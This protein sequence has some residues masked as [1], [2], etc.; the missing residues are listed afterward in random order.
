[1]LLDSSDSSDSVK[2]V[3]HNSPEAILLKYANDFI[4]QSNF[5]QA[6]FIHE[7]LLPALIECGLEKPGDYTTGDEYENW[8]ISKVRQMN[9]ILRGHTNLP[10]R[11]MW[12]WLDVLPAPYGPSARKELLAQGSVLDVSIDCSKQSAKRADLAQLFREV[13][14][15][16][17]AGAV[18][19]ADGKYD[20]NDSP[21]QLLSLSN[22][23]TDVVELCVGELHAIGEV[24]DLS[25]KRGGVVVK[26]H[27]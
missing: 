25:G 2:D 9:A 24:I 20:A 14:D 10:M 1:M 4:A 18:V 21:E 16:M 7:L 22:E 17:E 5:S 3:L 15:V 23:L 19:A 8:R 27:K 6:K 12:V 26:I 11:W 13:A